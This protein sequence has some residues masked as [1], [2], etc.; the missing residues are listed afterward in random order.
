LS[1]GDDCA[2][3]HLDKLNIARTI[4]GLA[5][6]ILALVL[7][8]FAWVSFRWGD[9]WFK[10][11]PLAFMVVL[12]AVGMALIMKRRQVLSKP[13]KFLTMALLIIL[14]ASP[15]LLIASIRHQRG[16]LQ[17]RAKAFVSIPVPTALKPDSEGYMSYEYVGTNKEAEIQILGHSRELI[18]RYAT[19]GRI[20]WS[21]RIQGQFATTSE[22]LWFPGADDIQRT[23]QEVHAYLAER[24]AIL[25]EEWR[26]GFWQWVED[27]IEM[28]SKIPEHE[29]EDYHPA[30]TTNT[31]SL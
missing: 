30:A 6:L 2:E 23:N 14:I 5:C 31:V 24:N 18:E 26:M 9:L 22:Q 10:P 12:A 21:A 4:L 11:V 17:A 20:R 25:A 28:K 8:P 1:T 15:V 7:A 16:V 29:E 27:T 3:H 19:K 13:F